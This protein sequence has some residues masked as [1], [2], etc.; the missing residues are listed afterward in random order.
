MLKNRNR[1]NQ[2]KTNYLYV[3][4]LLIILIV[5]A[6]GWQYL[7]A[8]REQ[9]PEDQNPPDGGDTTPP[10]G[11]E[12]EIPD[13][14][15]TVIGLEDEVEITPDS[16]SDLTVIEAEASLSRSASWLSVAAEP[17]KP[18]TSSDGVLAPLL[19]MARRNPRML[20]TPVPAKLPS[21]FRIVV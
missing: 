4:A 21:R 11:E 10:E 20:F 14:S 2:A 1:R 17:V 16:L 19:N 6:F 18:L 9:T 15:I 5:A 12:P 13:F 3:A 7:S 8:P